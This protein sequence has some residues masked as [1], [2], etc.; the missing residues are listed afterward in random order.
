M[1]NGYSGLT[2]DLSRGKHL[3]SRSDDWGID[4]GGIDP[5]KEYPKVEII[6]EDGSRQ[7]ASKILAGSLKEWKA[8]TYGCD[9]HKWSP[10]RCELIPIGRCDITACP[11]RLAFKAMAAKA[12]NN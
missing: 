9:H 5:H 1:S 11:I 7:L 12:Q 8:G 4:S 2:E 10:E 6:L 3:R